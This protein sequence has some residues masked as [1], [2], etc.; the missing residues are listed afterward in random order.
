MHAM[1]PVIKKDID[2]FKRHLSELI[3]CMDIKKLQEV[4][5]SKVVEYN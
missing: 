4:H 5:A 3:P 2:L 1:D